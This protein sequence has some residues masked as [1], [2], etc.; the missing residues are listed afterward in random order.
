MTEAGRYAIL[1]ERGLLAVGGA[2]ARKFLQG[3]VSG[4]IDKVTPG[5]AIYA[6]LLTPQG[7]FLHDFF[8]VET[9]GALVFDCEGARRDD[10]ERR[11]TFYRLRAEVTFEAFDQRYFAAAL[12]GDGAPGAL[13]LATAEGSA[14]GFAGGVVY[15]DPRLAAMGARAVLPREGGAEALE[16]AGF[17]PAPADAYDRLRLGHA[18]PDGSRDMLVEKGFLLENGLEELNGVDFDKGCYVGQELTAR[19][20]HRGTIRKRLYRVDVDGAL[21]EPGTPVTFAG[22]DAGEMRSGRGDVGLALLRVE[23]AEKAA[24]A[25]E[26]LT[27]GDARLTPVK[28]DWAAF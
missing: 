15:T 18:V 14:A 12:M 5:R 7:K 8:I 26:P 25:G 4:D 21:P 1:E 19:T 6:T 22:S 3:I 9:G 10:L 2:E 17:A 27:A 23:L 16:A 28:P 20:K 11:L 24:A 13:G